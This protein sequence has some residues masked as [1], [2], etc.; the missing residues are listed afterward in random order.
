M[1]LAVENFVFIVC[2]LMGGWLPRLAVLL[3]P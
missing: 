2:T 3:D 1:A